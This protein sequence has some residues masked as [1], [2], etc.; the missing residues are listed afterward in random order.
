V[1]KVLERG[2]FAG[3]SIY[4]YTKMGNERLTEFVR[5]FGPER[6]IADSACDWGV[7]DPLAVPKT[8]HSRPSGAFRRRNPLGDIRERAGRLQL[9]R[10]H[11]GVGLA[12]SSA[13][14]F[15]HAVP[16]KQRAARRANAAQRGA[17]AV[18]ARSQRLFEK[19][20]IGGISSVHCGYDC[21]TIP[22]R[23]H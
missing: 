12:G 15:A 20:F 17:M 13:H 21:N 14:R 22:D 19:L 8:A 9:E 7:S 3:C 5:H 1:H 6:I 11:A 2:Y 4:P 23:P 16:G 10:G 18:D